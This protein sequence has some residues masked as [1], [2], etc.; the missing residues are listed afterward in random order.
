[1]TASATR[2]V[3]F[4]LMALMAATAAAA[5]P[6]DPDEAAPGGATTA[7]VPYPEAAFAQPMGNLPGSEAE[8][9]ATGADYF[10]R[11]WIAGPAAAPALTGLGPLYNALS[12]AQC[13]RNDGRGRPPADDGDARSFVLKFAP[14]H[15]AYGRQLQDRAVL[16]ATPEGAPRVRWRDVESVIPGVKMRAPEYAVTSPAFGAVEATRLSGRIAPPVAGVGLLADIPAARIAALADPDDADGDGISGRLPAGRFGWRGEA[17]TVNGQTA[18]AFAADM[19]VATRLRPGEG[20]EADAA[21]F[22]AVVF[23]TENLGPPERGAIDTPDLMRGREAFHA[24]GCAAC[25]TPSHVTGTAAPAWRA[26]QKIWPYTDLLLHDMGDGLADGDG[27]EWRTPPLWGIGR[28]EAV[29]GDA[30]YLHDGRARSLTEAILWH[31]GEAAAARD[32]FAAA[33]DRRR[34]ALLAFLESL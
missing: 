9:F 25:H 17:A 29:G 22:D 12:C 8:R 34:R 1:M 13:H 24:F 11:R 26:S 31:G 14:P 2:T 27:P 7:T 21:I 32:A 4:G 33:T 3:F 16:G 5:P 19:G 10:Y 23:Y 28:T 18:E 6:L 20:V 15:P 30:Y